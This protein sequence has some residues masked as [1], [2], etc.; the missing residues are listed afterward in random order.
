MFVL[1]EL[2]IFVNNSNSLNW[3]YGSFKPQR[4]IE[5]MHLYCIG[6]SC[7]RSRSAVSEYFNIYVAII[8]VVVIAVYIV[9]FVA[10]VRIAVR[11]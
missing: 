1:L 6:V 2:R 3:F 8:K 7:C 9:V 4:V 11:L 5:Q 10:V